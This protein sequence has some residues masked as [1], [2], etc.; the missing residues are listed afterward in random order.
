MS[1]VLLLIQKE[2]LQILR[3]KAMIPILLLGPLIQLIILS[4][5]ATQDIKNLALAVLDSDH[6]T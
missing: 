6:S 5:S 4:Y 3:N 2:L 1:I